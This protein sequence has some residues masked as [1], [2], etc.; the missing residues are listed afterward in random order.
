[1]NE[2]ATNK[3]TNKG[4]TDKNTNKTFQ[5]FI[6]PISGFRGAE[7]PPRDYDPPSPR[8][9]DLVDHLVERALG[10]RRVVDAVARAHDADIVWFLGISLSKPA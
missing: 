7:A 10:E 4:F 9:T 6:V 1:M 2:C 5:D 8:R 3:N